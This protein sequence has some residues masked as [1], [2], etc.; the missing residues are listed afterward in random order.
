MNE[1]VNNEERTEDEINPE[2]EKNKTPEEITEE[3]LD[4]A[5]EEM[6]KVN[7]AGDE[8]VKG[9]E[10]LNDSEGREISDETEKIRDETKDSFDEFKK[11]IQESDIKLKWE[12]IEDYLKRDMESLKEYYKDSKMKKDAKSTIEDHIKDLNGDKQIE[13][14][15][16]N[17]LEKN[18]DNIQRVR[19][20]ISERFKD[21]LGETENEKSEVKDSDL[22]KDISNID[23]DELEREIKEEAETFE[24]D[25][26]KTVDDEVDEWQEKSDE[27]KKEDIENMRKEIETDPRMEKFSKE[28]E[29]MREEMEALKDETEEL[30]KNRS[31]ITRTIQEQYAGGAVNFSELKGLEQEKAKRIFSELAEITDKS[32]SV[33]KLDYILQDENALLNEHKAREISIEALE[34][35]AG[36]Y[37]KIQKFIEEDSEKA[38][39][40]VAGMLGRL[41]KIKEGNPKLFALLVAAGLVAGL[42]LLVSALGMGWPAWLTIGNALKTGAVAGGIA[43]AC[44]LLKNKKVQGAL[45]AGSSGILGG[46]AMLGEYLMKEETRDGAVE[47]LSGMK[48]PKIAY[49]FSDK[50]RGEK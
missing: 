9:A 6:K 17:S 22:E 33:H 7:D 14:L 39:E 41:K 29:K 40:E 24:D 18:E 38:K 20:M 32:L 49:L 50:K 45:M 30:I 47:L 34:E 13:F 11:R 12:R 31:E 21:V 26:Q 19:E 10:E 42:F 25:F 27:E 43:G 16:G 2:G 1:D 44:L 5:G 23:A 35:M 8:T 3:V 4:N 48:V 46:V 37:D 28:K 36:I 15:L